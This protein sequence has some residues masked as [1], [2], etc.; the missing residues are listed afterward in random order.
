[1]NIRKIRKYAGLL[2]IEV[3]VMPMLLHHGKGQGSLEY[4]MMIATASIVI[5]MALVMIVKL[6]TAI[7]TSVIV[8][9]TNYSVP[10]AIS[11]Q[12]SKLSIS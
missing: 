2:P 8:N 12:L 6:K 3:R 9:G 11:Q 7:P 1:M 5:V 4:V 10:G